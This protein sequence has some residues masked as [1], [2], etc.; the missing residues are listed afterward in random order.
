MHHVP[1]Y[2]GDIRAT[3]SKGMY[4]N[5]KLSIAHISTSH[6]FP[7]FSPKSYTTWSTNN[8]MQQRH[9]LFSL[10]FWKKLKVLILSI[11]DMRLILEQV[12]WNW[13]MISIICAWLTNKKCRCVSNWI[14]EIG[15]CMQKDTSNLSWTYII[16]QVDTGAVK[17][18]IHWLE[19]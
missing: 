16:K 9:T 12:T 11:R 17:I 15:T 6:F 18:R 13:P 10:F 3:T 1:V 2:S 4:S 8:V 7:E 14:I 19:D 5:L